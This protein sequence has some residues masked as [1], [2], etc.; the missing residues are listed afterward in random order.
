MT[1]TLK[2]TCLC[3]GVEYEVKDPE[4]SGVLSLHSLPAVDRVEPGRGG[5]R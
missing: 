1:D 5:R 3:G 4:G 2:G